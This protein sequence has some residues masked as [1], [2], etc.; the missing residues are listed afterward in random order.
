[1]YAKHR[2]TINPAVYLHCFIRPRE[3]MFILGNF[4]RWLFLEPRRLRKAS[5]VVSALIVLA[6]LQVYF[7]FI[8]DVSFT[9]EYTL[10][11][12]VV[13]DQLLN[14]LQI[15]N[16]VF[17]KGFLPPMLIINRQEEHS[18][19]SRRGGKIVPKNQKDRNKLLSINAD[20]HI[21]RGFASTQ[22]EEKHLS[23]LVSSRNTNTEDLRQRFCKEHFLTRTNKN[24]YGTCEPHQPTA[25]ACILAQSFYY[26]DRPATL[27]YRNARETR[28]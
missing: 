26:Y 13:E 28:K 9:T 6:L 21:N 24:S 10:C 5:I 19:I 23:D 4:L 27:L 3:R 25:D 12:R 8:A 14:H 20:L 16:S 1:M 17:K 7:I 22:S 18:F 11:A 15:Y 2:N